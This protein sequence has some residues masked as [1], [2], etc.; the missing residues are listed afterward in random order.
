MAAPTKKSEASA[1]GRRFGENVI[2]LR[3]Q[4][5]LSQQAIAER[6][7]LH[8]VEV[9][10]IERGLRVPRL[11]TILKLAGAVEVDPCELIREMRWENATDAR[12]G[13]FIL[14]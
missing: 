5:G 13:R 14:D 10:L 8:R 9:S 11:E 2:W 6:A 3:K 1:I 12:P 4:A 7:G